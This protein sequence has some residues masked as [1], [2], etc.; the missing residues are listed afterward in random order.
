[1]K[2]EGGGSKAP[3]E[4]K[5]ARRSESAEPSGRA[6]KRSK[7]GGGG[8]SKARSCLLLAGLGVLG[9]AL[10]PL[11]R[12]RGAVPCCAGRRAAWCPRHQSP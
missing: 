8:G 5:R 12:L 3:A 4:R 7:E 9:V 6:S 11:P 1:M 10:L 2:K